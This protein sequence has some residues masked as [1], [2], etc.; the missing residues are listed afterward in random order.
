[1][2]ACNNENISY[3]CHIIQTIFASENSVFVLAT[4]DLN[5]V[6]TDIF[7][8]IQFFLK[9][10]PLTRVENLLTHIRVRRYRLTRQYTDIQTSTY[11]GMSTQCKLKV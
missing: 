7:Q 1:M 8:W 9:L 5:L 6:K 10:L 4:V 3:C 11:T 2:S